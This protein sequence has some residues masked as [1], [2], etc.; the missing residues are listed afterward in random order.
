MFPIRSDMEY[1][2]LMLA[3][4]VSAFVAYAVSHHRIGRPVAISLMCVAFVLL[5]VSFYFYFLT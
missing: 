4:A 5:G 2:T 3:V 1:F